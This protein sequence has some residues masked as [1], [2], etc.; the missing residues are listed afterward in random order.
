MEQLDIQMLEKDEGP[1]PIPVSHTKLNSQGIID[2]NVKPTS[3]KHLKGN[4]GNDIFD[5]EGSKKFLSTT[6]KHDQ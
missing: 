6:T 1:V 2:P 4:T 3:I 5:L